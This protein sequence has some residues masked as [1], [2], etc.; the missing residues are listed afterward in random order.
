[1]TGSLQ[2]KNGKYYMVINYYDNGKRKQKWICTELEIK[3]NKRLAEQMLRTQL[4]SFEVKKPTSDKLFSDCIKDWLKIIIRRVDEVTFQGYKTLADTQVL[5]YFEQNK[6]KLGEIS[7]ANLQ[8]YFDYKAKNGRK[9]GKGGLS[10]SSL[11]KIKN[12]INQ[13]LNEAVKN[14]VIS[15]NPCQFVVLPKIEKYQS[16]FYSAKQLQTMFK[17]FKGDPLQSLVFI[18]S[19]YGLRR[20]EV[21]GLKWDSIDFENN[22]I[23]IKHTVS[24]V[25]KTVEKDKTKN[26]SSYRSFPLTDETKSI[27]IQAKRDEVENSNLFGK[28]YNKNDYVFK[29]A[30]GSPMSPDFV[31]KH[32]RKVL[33]KNGLPLIRFHELRHSCAS[34]LLNNGMSLKDTQDWLG[35]SDIKMTANLYGH[36]DY[37]RKRDMAN[38]LSQNVLEKC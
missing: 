13:T 24:K 12:I 20:S 14:G 36:L 2:I 22:S 26:A 15:S 31:S 23:T 30:D 17:A 27:F 4:Q 33:I 3:G 16:N 29:W 35:H 11:R 32:F 19:F 34:L 6:L 37:E 10:P 38:L 28:S 25:T 5:P 21:L 1:M 7:I 18:T 8:D 9:D